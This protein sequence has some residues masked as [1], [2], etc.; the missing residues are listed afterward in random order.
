MQAGGKA[1]WGWAAVL[2][3]LRQC[4]QGIYQGKETRVSAMYKRW[5]STL[6]IALFSEAV[7]KS[8]DLADGLTRIFQESKGVLLSGRDANSP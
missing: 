6:Y 4:I 1:S 7:R 3:A 5:Q 8:T 2:K